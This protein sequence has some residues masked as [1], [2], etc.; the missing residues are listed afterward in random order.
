MNTCLAVQQVLFWETTILLWATFMGLQIKES[1]LL[2]P[3]VGMRLK[4]QCKATL[5][6]LPRAIREDT[7]A[8]S[9]DI[10]S[11]EWTLF[12]F[13]ITVGILT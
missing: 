13:D 6:T 7:V 1:F 3:K 10:I 12:L 9:M 2:T 11:Q 4:P 5:R 8:I